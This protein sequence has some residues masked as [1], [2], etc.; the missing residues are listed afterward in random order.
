MKP[1]DV[2]YELSKR[3]AV[4]YIDLGCEKGL[5]TS[6]SDAGNVLIGREKALMLLEAGEDVFM[7]DIDLLADEL[8]EKS[9]DTKIT[10]SAVRTLEG[11][12]THASLFITK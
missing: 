4:S 1:I 6:F 5:A 7:S 12:K 3:G 8:S 11:D 2:G 10:L 9:G